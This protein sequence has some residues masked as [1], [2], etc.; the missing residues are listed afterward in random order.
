[1]HANSQIVYFW[2][3][4]WAHLTMLHGAISTT[5]LPS[6]MYVFNPPAW[7]LS[8]EWQFY[9]LAPLVILLTNKKKSRV[10]AVLFI[11]ILFVLYNLGVFGIYPPHSLLIGSA[12]LFAV[13]IASRLA[14]PKLRETLRRL[15]VAIALLVGLVP[16]GW[17][18]APVL[19]WGCIYA[20]LIA[21]N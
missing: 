6:G 5:I 12:P 10:A 4:F 3:N 17:N 2:P 8:L 7:S 13:G 9:L 21:D 11:T 15:G 20:I 1:G 18:S 14:Y 19:V 16:L